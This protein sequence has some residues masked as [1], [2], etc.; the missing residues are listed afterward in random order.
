[1][2]KNGTRI[3]SFSS[4]TYIHVRVHIGWYDLHLSVYMDATNVLIGWR[5]SQALYL[6]VFKIDE[7][8]VH[9]NQSQ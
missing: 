8:I 4:L 9:D 6:W 1:M 5:R 2:P 3:V 7:N